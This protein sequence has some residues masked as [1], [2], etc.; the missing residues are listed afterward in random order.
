MATLI[1]IAGSLRKASVNQSLLNAAAQLMPAG[2]SLELGTLEGIPLYNE[3]VESTAGIPAAVSRLQ[4]QIAAGDGLIIA[5]PEYNNAM[6]GVLKNAMDWLT[7]PPSEIGRV[8]KDRPV[9]LVGATPGGF[10][11]VLAQ[12]SWLP[13]MRTLGVRLWTGGRMQVSKAG[14]VFDESGEMVDE[15]V[16]ERLRVYMEG[17]VEFAAG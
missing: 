17:F 10:G 15:D 14:T 13:V 1:G 12:I 7:R 16:R 8:F 9:A 2:S 3:D 4:D 5:T 6:P 11:T